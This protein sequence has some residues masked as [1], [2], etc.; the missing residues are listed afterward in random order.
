VFTPGVSQLL[1]GEISPFRGFEEACWL[2][3]LS[4][5][6]SERAF[7]EQLL[8][9]AGRLAKR[10]DQAL[11]TFPSLATAFKVVNGVVAVGIGSGYE[12]QFP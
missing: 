2:R 3:P 9:W 5:W 12:W 10:G 6:W 1:V 8:I 4:D 11:R 7:F